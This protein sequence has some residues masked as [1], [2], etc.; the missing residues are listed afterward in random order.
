MN[1]PIAMG[2]LSTAHVHTDAYASEL[3]EREDVEFAGVTD[4]DSDRGQ[5]TAERHDTEYVADAGALLERI[6]AA[7]ICAPNADHR[8]W[9]ERAAAAGVHVLC[10]KPLAPT[11]E[12]AR[13]IVDVWQE[14]GIRAGITMPLRFCGPA[15]RAKETLDAG[16]VG[17]LLAISGTNRG[18]MPGGWFV[19]PKAA[20]GGAVMDHSV[21]IVDLVYHLTGQ[22]VTEVY[23]EVG[24]RFH[25]IAVDDVNVLSMELADGTPFFLDGSWSKP[26]AWH[27]WGDATLELTGTDA[28]VGI[29]YTDQS[30]VHTAESG[31]N[32]GVHTAFY[33]TNA[34]A[35][36]IEDFV[37]SVRADRE[38]EITPDDGLLAVAVVEAAYE[39]AETGEPVDVA[40]D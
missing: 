26:D 14:S 18:Q 15:Q 1:E 40:F 37:S 29:D 23:A 36:L 28:T 5:E 2:V 16:E 32:A 12:D 33:G 31:S 21:H 4:R 9:F 6:D 27:T 20:G 7:V 10:E 38:P 35:G 11:L 22:A 13:A 39:S 3:A 17:D 30:L 8:E 25:D 24:T 34:N 19:D